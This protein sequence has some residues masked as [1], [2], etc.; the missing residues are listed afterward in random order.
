MYSPTK[1][2]YSPSKLPGCENE[3]VE[4]IRQACQLLCYS[5]TDPEVSKPEMIRVTHTH[6]VHV[7]TVAVRLGNKVARTTRQ[8]NAEKAKN[9]CL[10]REIAR[11]TKELAT[12]NHLQDISDA[13]LI[14]A[15][16][17]AEAPEAAEAIANDITVDLPV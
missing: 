15:A 8:I 1:K 4:E 3:D 13:E 12:Q 7:T 2:M 16:E 11:L 14:G 17:A 5:S 10:T 9:K 6:A